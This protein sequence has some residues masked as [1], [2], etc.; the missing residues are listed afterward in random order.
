MIFE[1]LMPQQQ[2]QVFTLVGKS[3]VPD[4]VHIFEAIVP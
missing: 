3:Y 2:G 4:T 1:I